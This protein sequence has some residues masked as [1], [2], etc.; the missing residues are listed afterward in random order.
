MKK[1]MRYAIFSIILAL[2]CPVNT[3]AMDILQGNAES[4]PMPQKNIG[5]TIIDNLGTLTP[6]EHGSI[7]GKDYVSGYN[8]LILNIIPLENIKSITFTNTTATPAPLL[9]K[10]DNA[11]ILATL[12]LKDGKVLS[13][14]VNGNLLCYGKTPYGY[15]R[16]KLSM[17]DKIEDIKLLKKEK[18]GKSKQ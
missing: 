15:I 16:I 2:I 9:E 3:H 6:I 12:N 13:I 5:F 4:I 7:D 11:P 1:F 10:L 18:P 8:G 14:I 17:I